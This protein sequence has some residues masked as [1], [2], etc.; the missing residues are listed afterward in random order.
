MF[1]LKSVIT[2]AIGY[3]GILKPRVIE[4]LDLGDFLLAKLI[5]ESRAYARGAYPD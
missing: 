3:S 1:W 2:Q 4:T 5:L